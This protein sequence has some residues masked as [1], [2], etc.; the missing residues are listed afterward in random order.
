MVRSLKLKKRWLS[1]LQSH[2]IAH[3]IEDNC[4]ENGIPLA[5]VTGNILSKMIKYCKKHIIV[6]SNNDGG[7]TEAE[8]KEWN[9]KFMNDIDQ[10][11]L[12]HLIMAADFQN[13]KTLINL[14]F[15]KIADMISCKPP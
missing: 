14:T 7:S 13:I 12:F 8:L 2:V 10:S 6:V 1:S 5:N 15:Q 11:K 9:T 4:V 3:M